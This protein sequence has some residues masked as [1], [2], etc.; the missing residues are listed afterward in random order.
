MSSSTSNSDIT[1]PRRLSRRWLMGFVCMLTLLTLCGMAFNAWYA[2]RPKLVEDLQE[3]QLTCF[4]IFSPERY[5]MVASGSSRINFGLDPESMQPYLPGIRI[6]NCAMF[7]GSINHEILEYLEQRKIDWD[8][9]R[10]RIVLLEITPRIMWEDL[11]KN[12][13]YRSILNKPPDEIRR[14]MSYSPDKRFSFHN[15]FMPMD[16]ERWNMRQKR[17][18]VTRPHCHVDTGWY[19]VENLATTPEMN[20]GS[21]LKQLSKADV[22]R[23]HKKRYSI[24]RSFSEILEKTRAWSAKGV[25]VF[26]VEP[27]IDPRIKALEEELSDYDAKRVHALFREAGGIMIPVSGQYRVE[28]GGSHLDSREAK[29]F[30]TEIAQ[31]IA[32][33]CAKR[34]TGGRLQ[35]AQP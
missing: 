9:P 5:D 17:K 28:L 27:P 23:A 31:R 8:S 14:L 16:R 19:E 4:K 20:E 26:G 10:Q 1:A 7:G 35:Q 34:S 18:S 22:M 30:S 2:A 12:G 21:V 6:H 13:S 11:R 3:L 29:R 32:E 33:E 25:L 15:F 24:D